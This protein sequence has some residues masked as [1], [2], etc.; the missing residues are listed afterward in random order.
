MIWTFALDLYLPSLRPVSKQPAQV[1]CNASYSNEQPG[2]FGIAFD[3]AAPGLETFY[4]YWFPGQNER[5]IFT[6]YIAF[7]FSRLFTATDGSAASPALERGDYRMPGRAYRFFIHWQLLLTIERTRTHYGTVHDFPQ[8]RIA[9]ISPLS[10][11]GVRRC[12]GLPAQFNT[13]TG[14]GCPFLNVSL[15]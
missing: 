12:R 8:Y 2:F 5:R 6:T 7:P 15:L 1:Y 4:V 3:P 14:E 10:G 9:D 11:G 13:F